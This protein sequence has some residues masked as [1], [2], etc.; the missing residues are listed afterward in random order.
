[1]GAALQRG[2]ELGFP[3]WNG[4]SAISLEVTRILEKD[5]LWR[6]QQPYCGESCV[7][8]RLGQS[9]EEKPNV[10][11]TLSSIQNGTP[12]GAVGTLSRGVSQEQP[13]EL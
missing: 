12:A 1:M 5:Q 4:E 13:A 11:S 8:R 6:H 9:L 7:Q 2:S 3:A 10:P